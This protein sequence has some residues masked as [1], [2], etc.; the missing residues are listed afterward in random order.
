MAHDRP[1]W[2]HRLL[3][4]TDHAIA[5]LERSEND[6]RQG[7]VRRLRLL[8]RHLLKELQGLNPGDATGLGE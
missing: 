5:E 4:A 2:L 3:D 1:D 7:L 6:E 8:R